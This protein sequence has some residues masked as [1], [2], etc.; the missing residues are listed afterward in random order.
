MN[1]DDVLRLPI[2][3]LISG[4]IRIPCQDRECSETIEVE[5]QDI[6]TPGMGAGLDE[7]DEQLEETHYFCEDCRHKYLEECKKVDYLLDGD[8]HYL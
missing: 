7:I 4:T 2:G 5:I 8:T 6:T 1:F 3:S